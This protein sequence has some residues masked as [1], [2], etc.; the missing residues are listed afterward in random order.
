MSDTAELKA[1]DF[2]LTPPARKTDPKV[3]TYNLEEI[4]K[5]AIQNA[6]KKHKG[7]LTLAAKELGFGRST[8]Y[9]RMEKYGL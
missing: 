8:L 5:A 1:A 2:L 4:E 6:I 3:Q 7:N 9:R